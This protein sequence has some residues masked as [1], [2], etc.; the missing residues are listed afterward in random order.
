MT[1]DRTPDNLKAVGAR[2]RAAR[3][4]LG[5]S[6]KDL[7]EPLDVKA[8]TWNHWE[9]GKRLPDPMVMARLKELHGITTDWIYAGDASALPFAL[10]RTLMKAAS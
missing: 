4:A 1:R 3:L 8:A 6:Q 7:Y 10:A 5:L 2:L 9:S